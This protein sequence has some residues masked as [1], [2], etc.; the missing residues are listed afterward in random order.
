MPEHRLSLIQSALP[1]YRQPVVDELF[2]TLGDGLLVYVG[3]DHFDPTLRTDLTSRD[4]V[5]R[6]RNLYLL[7]RRFLW[8]RGALK[9]GIQADRVLLELNPR[10]LTVW[11]TLIIRRL[12]GR[13]TT[14]WGHAWPR[15]GKG[16]R[17]DIVRGLLRRL[18]DRVVVYTET[19]ARE[20]RE[21]RPD[22]SVFAAPNALYYSSQPGPEIELQEIPNRFIYV[23]RLI[24]SKKPRLLLE[25]FH[26]AIDGMAGASLLLVGA[27]PL[28]ESLEARASEL[29][30]EASV[31]FAG[32]VSDPAELRRLYSLSIASV[33]PGYVGLSLT[34]SLWFGIPMIIARD[35]PHAPEVEAAVVG[36]NAVFVPSDSVA[37]L[38]SALRE[39]WLHRDH[40]REHRIDIAARCRTTYSVEVMARGLVRSA[41]I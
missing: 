38:S 9:A 23:G 31:T 37:A 6:L 27:G 17:S 41:L 4:E 34:Q 16:A 36:E 11:A 12:T 39:A 32:H 7:R 19:Q 24:D 2:R 8:Q 26:E 1:H 18:A 13:P 22:S 20:L 21:R 25:A 35:E 10:I 28:R 29:G 33:S 14:L 40:W 5:I 30:L 15:K 3:D